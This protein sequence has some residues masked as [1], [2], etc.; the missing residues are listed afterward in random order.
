LSLPPL[1]N[2]PPTADQSLTMVKRAPTRK[3]ATMSK[4]A[5]KTKKRQSLKKR[6]PAAYAKFKA[7]MAGT[8]AAEISSSSDEES[9]S[10]DEETKLAKRYPPKAAAFEI[11]AMRENLSGDKE[12]VE[13]A[14]KKKLGE[15]QYNKGIEE[16]EDEIRRKAE[17]EERWAREETE[18]I[19]AEDDEDSNNADDES[20]ED[21]DNEEP[22]DISEAVAGVEAFKD[23]ASMTLD[24]MVQT[25]AHS[26]KRANACI[27]V[28]QQAY[29]RDLKKTDK[30]LAKKDKQLAVKDAEIAK[31]KRMLGKLRDE[32]KATE[33]EAE[34]FE[35]LEE[36]LVEIE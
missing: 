14:I 28:A 5:P 7:E 25:A 36:L 21:S 18:A 30:K 26:F 11:E 3:P 24:E 17:R 16:M 33:I 29:E 32:I 4:P 9:D 13:T 23:P 27:G 15:D 2:E 22:I 1:T 12:L 10:E 19:E 31:M 35:E 20:D 8:Y 6:N 34:T